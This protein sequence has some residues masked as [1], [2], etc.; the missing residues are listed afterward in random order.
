MKSSVLRG[1]FNLNIACCNRSLQY[2]GTTFQQI[3]KP[4]QITTISHWICGK[5]SKSEKLNKFKNNLLLPH[6]YNDVSIICL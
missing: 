4:L 1:K 2:H 6:P 3:L 5:M